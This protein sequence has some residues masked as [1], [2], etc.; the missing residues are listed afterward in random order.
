VH[1]DEKLKVGYKWYDAKKIDPLFPFGFGLSYTSYAYS[2][3]RVTSGDRL[4]VTCT[5]Q[6]TGEVSGTEIVEV[7]ASLPAAAAEP[8]Q[9][10][11]GWQRVQLNPGQSRDVSISIDKKLLTIYEADSNDWRLVPGDY[12]VMVGGSSQYLPLQQ[13]ITMP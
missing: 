13:S 8:P 7:Y 12:G 11:I 5:V 9:R 10:L 1:F 3:L 6:N 2:N 4:D